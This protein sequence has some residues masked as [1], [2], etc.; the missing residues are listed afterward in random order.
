VV[1]YEA[2]PYTVV[3]ASVARLPLRELPEH[4]VTAM[5]TLVIP[6]A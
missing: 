3:D 1:V 2:S 6:P 4:D 5:A